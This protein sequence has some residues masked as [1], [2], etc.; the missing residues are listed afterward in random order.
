MVVFFFLGV[1]MTPLVFKHLDTAFQPSARPFH[2]G[3]TGTFHGVLSYV[4]DAF[5]RAI[6]EFG[7]QIP[8]EALRAKLT[9]IVRQLCE[10]DSRL[11]GH[12]LSRST[13]G[14]SF[15]LER[16]I[17]DF[18]LLARRAEIGMYS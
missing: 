17:T 13:T 18:D 14:N 12:P 10:P 2:G 5:D 4:R 15:S 9:T 6:L 16:Y 1:G 3:W 8:N 11:R 7:G